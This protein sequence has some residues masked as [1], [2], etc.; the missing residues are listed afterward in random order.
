VVDSASSI[1]VL[2]CHEQPLVRAGLRAILERESGIKVLGEAATGAEAV[3]AASRTRPTIVIVDVSE[4]C[5]DAIEAIRLLSA[6]GAEQSIKVVV[7]AATDDE[8]IEAVRAGARG[9]VLRDCPAEEL[10]RATRA[11]AAS[12]GFI[13]PRIAACLL[14]NLARQLPPRG[15]RA[16]V[17]AQVLTP[18]EL[19][20]LCLL[21]R[22]HSNLEMA[23]VLSVSEATVRSHIHHLLTRLDLRDR[24]QAVAFAYEC[25]LVRP[26]WLIRMEHS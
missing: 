1:R 3:A 2:V 15:T 22:G 5:R 26:G 9:L 19:E 20:I 23:E 11:V 14:G 21:A 6:P 13:T 16:P 7:L 12:E 4:P 8:A 10:I 17:P 24:A 18:R 25:G